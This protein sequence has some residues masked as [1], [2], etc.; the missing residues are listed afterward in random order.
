[1]INGVCTSTKDVN[2][3]EIYNARKRINENNFVEINDN[4][5]SLNRLITKANMNILPSH[6][7]LDLFKHW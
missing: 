7:R 4:V 5:L 1:V 2:F 3:C 6:T